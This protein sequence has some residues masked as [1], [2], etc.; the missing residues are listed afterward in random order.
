ML[1]ETVVKTAGQI[2]FVL[3]ESLGERCGGKTLV[4][5]LS[6]GDAFVVY[7]DEDDDH[8]E[9]GI[10]AILRKPLPE[11]DN[12]LVA[13]MS[14]LCEGLDDSFSERVTEQGRSFLC[15]KTIGNE[16]AIY[17]MVPASLMA[18]R[19]LLWKVS[20]G[21]QR[22]PW[23]AGTVYEI[24]DRHCPVG[25]AFMALVTLEMLVATRLREPFPDIGSAMSSFVEQVFI[26]RDIPADVRLRMD[27]PSEEVCVENG[28]LAGFAKSVASRL[29][30]IVFSAQEDS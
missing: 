30:A 5:E 8:F 6:V 29:G 19:F 2:E 4:Q 3:G 27:D 14:D 23:V 24:L 13:A 11:H 20:G 16:A 25:D 17:R 1:R 15:S 28:F 26:G 9:K 12:I 18:A 10:A 7:G 22:L 21:R